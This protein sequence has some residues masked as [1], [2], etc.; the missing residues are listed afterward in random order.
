MNYNNNLY[1][2]LF[3]LKMEL[4]SMGKNDYNIE[5]Y[6]Q[7]LILK[8]NQLNNLKGLVEKKIHLLN[9]LKKNNHEFIK[10]KGIY[11]KVYKNNILIY[12][13]IYNIFEVCKYF[14]NKF[15]NDIF[16][17]NSNNKTKIS[18]EKEIILMLEYIE[19][20]IDFLITKFIF[21]V[22]KGEDNKNLIKKIKNDIEKE[23]KMN[24]TKLLKIID[25]EKIR[26][27]KEKLQKK[28]NKIYILNSRKLDLYD[29]F[30]I[31][32][33]KKNI[34]LESKGEPTIQDYLY[35]EKETA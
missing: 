18:K 2:Q 10:N 14:K 35:E 20:V 6:N 8:T 19:Q 12:N 32:K 22:N 7:N 26:L 34:N 16:N 30:K 9:D 28:N 31:S 3:R 1:N 17:F 33:S 25:S 5:E 24:K 15:K 27:L 11:N 23:H 21:Y 29:K 4:K 13:K